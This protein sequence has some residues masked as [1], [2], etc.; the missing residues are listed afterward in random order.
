MFHRPL[1]FTDD[2][3][4]HLGEEEALLDADYAEE[5]EEELNEVEMVEDEDNA[6]SVIESDEGQLESVVEDGYVDYQQIPWEVETIPQDERLEG[7][8]ADNEDNDG[9]DGDHVTPDHW[10]EGVLKR[11]LAE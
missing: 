10:E 6:Q 7:Y 1:K 2:Q 9:L 11:S 3:D 5:E 8:E 4:F